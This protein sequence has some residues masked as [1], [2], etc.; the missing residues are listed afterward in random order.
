MYDKLITAYEKGEEELA[1]VLGMTPKQLDDE[2]LMT[3][4]FRNPFTHGR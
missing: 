2:L 1:E 3:S 4:F